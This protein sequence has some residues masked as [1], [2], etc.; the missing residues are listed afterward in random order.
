VDKL[1]MSDKVVLVTGAAGGFGRRS[2]EEFARAGAKVI[3]S[4]LDGEGAAQTARL[5]R[6]LGAQAW[7]RPHDV[8]K[9]DDW[10]R[11]IDVCIQHAGG[12][13]DA[14]VNNAGVML[15]RPFLKTSLA[16]F[17]RLMSVNVESMWIGS[18]QAHPLLAHTAA[19]HGAASIVNVSSVFGL[20]GAFAQAAYSASKGAVT[21]LTKSVALEFARA[22]SG[23]RVNSVHPGPGNTALAI[24]GL[25]EMIKEGLAQSQEEALGYVASLIP[26]GRFAEPEDVAQ[27]I[28]FLCSDLSRYITG[29]ELVVDGG[30]MA[31]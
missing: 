10:N 3:A 2:C 21:L 25:Q 23:I 26:N 30:Y 4:D 1:T 27:V 5:C 16:D 19:V 6:E 28:L 29:A 20:A 15:T 17:R 14:L 31:A 8:T 9:E 22:G 13:L 7:G 11:V 18:Q 12:R 24:N